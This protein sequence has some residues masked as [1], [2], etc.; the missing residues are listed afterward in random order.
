MAKM[1]DLGIKTGRELEAYG[2]MIEAGFK[3]KAIRGRILQIAR[4]RRLDRI[5][6][7]R[8]LQASRTSK[9]RNGS[10]L[11]FAIEHDINLNWLFFGDLQGLMS[12]KRMTMATCQG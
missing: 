4:E 2:R 3:P 12:M 9:G 11:D 8:A 7:D 10:L 5:E 1:M 6:V